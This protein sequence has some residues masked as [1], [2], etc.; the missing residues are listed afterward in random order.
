MAQ[1]TSAGRL[2][3]AAVIARTKAVLE[4]R[5]DEQRN[6]GAKRQANAGPEVTFESLV[7]GGKSQ[8]TE[9]WREKVKADLAAQ[10]EAGGTLYGFE[11]DGTC[12]ERT[13]DGDRV[14]PLSVARGS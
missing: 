8:M 9:G 6:S 14:I 5:P 13:K 4:E 3:V 11:D 10:V 1:E 2:T 7:A 12:I